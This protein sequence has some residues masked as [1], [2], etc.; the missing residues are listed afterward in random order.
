[1]SDSYHNP[2]TPIY[3]IAGSAG[4]NEGLTDK[5]ETKPAWSAYRDAKLGYGRVTVTDAK[6]LTWEYVHAHS[7]VFVAYQLIVC[8]RAAS[9]SCCQ[10][11]V[12][13]R[14]RSP[15]PSRRSC[16]RQRG[17]GSGGRRC[18]PNRPTQQSPHELPSCCLCWCH[19][20][21]LF[22]HWPLPRSARQHCPS[23]ACAS[24]EAQLSLAG[25]LGT[26]VV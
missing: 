22:T 17:G 13:C 8:I 20:L 12:P 18:F 15:S 23:P 9:V 26:R 4:D 24:T 16:R 6:T 1:M 14:T 7:C 3:V 10:K 21:V 11:T 19:F 2:K 25:G 5:W